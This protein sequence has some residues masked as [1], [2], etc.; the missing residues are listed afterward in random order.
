MESPIPFQKERK[1]NIRLAIAIASLGVLG[2]FGLYGAF[3]LLMIFY[4][5]ALFNLLAFPSFPEGVV[6]L[7]GK[8][9]ILSKTVH[10]KG[11]RFGTPPEER[12]VLKV[13]DGHS[14]SEVGETKPFHSLY[15]TEER[16]YFFSKGGYR[17]FDG[18]EWA[19]FKHPAIG[20]DPKAAVG[21]EGIW[22]LS[23]LGKKPE[24]RL[25]TEHETKTVDLPEGESG[26]MK[27]VCSTRL[28]CLGREL[29]LFHQNGEGLAWYRYD[30]EKWADLET[31]GE[32]GAYDIV[33]FKE[34]LLLLQR[35]SDPP[36]GMSLRIYHNQAWSEPK[37]LEGGGFGISFRLA[38]F[39]GRPIVFQQGFLSERYYFIE[40]D[41]LRGPFHVGSPWFSK[42]MLWKGILIAAVSTVV[43]IV[44]VFLLSLFFDKLKLKTWRVDSR[45]YEFASLFRRFLADLI[46]MLITSLPFW[47][48]LFLTWEEDWF[49]EDLPK[50]LLVGAL[51]TLAWML[52][53]FLYRSLAEGIWGKTIGKK[54]C[55][56]VVLR[57]DFTRCGIGSGLLR[58]LMRL[59]DSFFCYLVAAVSVAG[60]LHWQRLGDLVGGTIVVRDREGPIL[61]SP[62]SLE[63]QEI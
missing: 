19:D 35:R 43:M 13:Y 59:V 63:P 27:S 15:A 21:T 57:D 36:T 23:T 49:I 61:P 47:I 39:Q 62:L 22:V 12:T 58:N 50:S 16:I 52:G 11:G 31:L 51:S 7:K 30:G 45:V 41:R 2:S 44:M 34:E 32:R 54:I 46:D 14:L 60:T 42:P 3:L 20:K 17:T 18:K 5:G 24:L 53:S 9:W 25:L 40:R 56:I 26:P 33:A 6:G 8:L 55:G 38:L 1:K 29:H 28:V 37:E 4:P 10:F 48:H